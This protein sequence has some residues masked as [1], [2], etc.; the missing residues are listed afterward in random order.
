[1]DRDTIGVPSKPIVETLTECLVQGT[2]RGQDQ[3][4]RGQK[5]QWREGICMHKVCHPLKEEERAHP[6]QRTL[7][8]EGKM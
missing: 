6:L 8:K 7:G 4:W 1:M 5:G 3:R 2:G